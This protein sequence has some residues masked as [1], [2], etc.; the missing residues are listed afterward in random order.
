MFLPGA[1]YRDIYR[2]N[3][4]TV[5]GYGPQEQAG[6]VDRYLYNGFLTVTFVY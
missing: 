1:G 2:R 6:K 3:T 5:F 4:A